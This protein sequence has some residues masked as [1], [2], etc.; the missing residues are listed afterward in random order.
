MEKPFF[1]ALIDSSFTTF[2]TRRVATVL[3]VILMVVI[4][5]FVA[6]AVVAGLISF[7]NDGLLGL[8]VILIGVLGGFVAL[9]LVRLGF[10]SAVAL[11]LAK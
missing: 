7:V 8:M 2:I 3:Y 11:G 10:E 1:A 4:A 5:V 6:I 9:I